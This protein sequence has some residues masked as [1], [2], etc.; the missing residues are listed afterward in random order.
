MP[1]HDADGFHW[2]LI[3]ADLRDHCYLMYDSSAATAKGERAALVNSTVSI[4]LLIHITSHFED[5]CS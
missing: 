5:M 1:L 3:A 2:L 4:T